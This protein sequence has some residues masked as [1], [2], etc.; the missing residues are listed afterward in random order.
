MP[1]KF[2]GDGSQ[3]QAFL[4]EVHL[5]IFTHPNN[6]DLDCLNLNLPFFFLFS[7]RTLP[8]VIVIVESMSKQE[9]V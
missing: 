3:F 8:R 2:D 1:K 6:Q 9:Y 5:V 7:L 4:N